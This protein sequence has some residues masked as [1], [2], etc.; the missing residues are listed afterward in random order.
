MSSLKGDYSG[1]LIFLLC[2]GLMRVWSRSR[3]G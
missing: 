1:L 3:R 2:W